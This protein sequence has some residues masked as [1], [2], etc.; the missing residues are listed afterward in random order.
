MFRRL[1]WFIVGAGAALYTRSRVLQAIDKYVPAPVSRA[2]QRTAGH[3]KSEI[4]EVSKDVRQARREQ[5][6]ARHA[7]LRNDREQ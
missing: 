6:N 4:V 3:L 2:I 1:F 5:K 7:E